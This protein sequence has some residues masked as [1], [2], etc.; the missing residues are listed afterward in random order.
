MPDQDY[1]KRCTK[2]GELK[3]AENFARCSESQDGLHWWCK[4][5]FRAMADHRRSVRSAQ[6]F[7]EPDPT[8]QRGC[9]ECKQMK[10]ETDFSRQK[11]NRHGFEYICKDCMRRRAI[12]RALARLEPVEPLLSPP[13]KLTPAYAAG[14]FDG[15]GCI[16]INKLKRRDISKGYHY[17]LKIQATNNVREV[18]GRFAEAYGGHIGLKRPR[19]GENR[20]LGYTWN[21]TSW[22]A[23][24][25]LKEIF[26][27]L[28][29][30]RQQAEI[31]FRFQDS[32]RHT[33]NR[34]RRAP[35]AEAHNREDL[36]Q[37][38]RKLNERGIANAHARS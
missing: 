5:C 3:T 10:P 17:T 33:G 25:F 38:I 20:K 8:K 29:V 16:S 34:W 11:M 18:I 21:V 37:Q 6:P 1:Q 13:D 12:M 23:I 2:C 27:F 36:Y 15:E 4:S 35:D 26:P 32:M 30:K 14:F 28:I 22:G 31:A 7:V 9:S 19:A 24:A